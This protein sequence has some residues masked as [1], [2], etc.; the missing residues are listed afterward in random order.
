MRTAQPLDRE[1]RPRLRLTVHVQDRDK[2]H[3]EC[4]SELTLTLT[5]VNDN[6]PVFSQVGVVARTKNF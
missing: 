5:D 6:A 1:T 3:W 2:P 4:T